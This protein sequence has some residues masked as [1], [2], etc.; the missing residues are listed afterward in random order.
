MVVLQAGIPPSSCAHTT[1]CT[2]ILAT[3][4]FGCC[5]SFL[6]LVCSNISARKTCSFSGG[7]W[8]WIIVRASDEEEPAIPARAPPEILRTS[9]SCRKGH[10]APAEMGLTHQIDAMQHTGTTHQPATTQRDPC[11]VSLRQKP[12]CHKYK[13]A[14]SGYVK[15]YG[16]S[17]VCGGP[18]S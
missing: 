13:R 2:Y 15:C 5:C 9:S 14:T 17:R 10:D 12:L 3:R 11:Q 8:W 1:T 18:P 6:F 7:G 4:L 16:R